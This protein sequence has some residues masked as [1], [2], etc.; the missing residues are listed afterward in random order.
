M[1]IVDK[2]KLKRPEIIELLESR[3]NF[4][5]QVNEAFFK[6][7]DY[8]EADYLPIWTKVGELNAR[9]LKGENVKDFLSM[10]EMILLAKHLRFYMEYSSDYMQRLNPIPK[11]RYRN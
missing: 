6:S 5:I 11:C 9:W 8:T 4:S 3:Q 1:P 7:V 2:S 10:K